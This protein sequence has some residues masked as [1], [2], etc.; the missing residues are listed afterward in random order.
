[1]Y[2]EADMDAMWK[3]RCA[4]DPKQIANRGKMFPSGEPAALRLTGLHPLEQAGIL[5]RE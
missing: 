4:L 5:S 1:M 3:L 2:A